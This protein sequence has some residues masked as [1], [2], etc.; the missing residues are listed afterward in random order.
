[1]VER[2]VEIQLRVRALRQQRVVDVRSLR[3]ALDRRPVLVLHQDDENGLDMML[4]FLLR[5]AAE[6]RQQDGADECERKRIQSVGPH[7]FLLRNNDES[8]GARGS[9]APQS[10]RTSEHATH[11]RWPQLS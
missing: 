2:R 4:Y 1:M 11:L 9:R 8:N 3:V 6:W 10:G 7:T 5:R